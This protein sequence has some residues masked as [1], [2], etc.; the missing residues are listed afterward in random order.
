MLTSRTQFS[1]VCWRK[2]D[3][4]W[5]DMVLFSSGRPNHVTNS[6]RSHGDVALLF[7]S[8]AHVVLLNLEVIKGD[9]KQ[10]GIG[11]V[12]YL[13]DMLLSL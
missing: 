4:P 12:F 1:G 8:R 3:L 11:A 6:G 9:A 7:G 13:K 2:Q 10:D 5:H